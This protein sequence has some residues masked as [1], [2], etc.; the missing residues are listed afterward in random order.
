MW[1]NQV[2]NTLQ[3]VKAAPQMVNPIEIMEYYFV[4]QVHQIKCYNIT[5]DI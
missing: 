5:I 1:K 3:I 2:V 4:K